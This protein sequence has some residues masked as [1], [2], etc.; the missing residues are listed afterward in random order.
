MQNRASMVTHLE[1]NDKTIGKYSTI[2]ESEI[3]IDG[4]TF[5]VIADQH[6]GIL[7]S[8][9]FVEETEMENE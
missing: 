3:D 7:N 5:N 6:A 2:I 9:N 4:K 8:L 1:F